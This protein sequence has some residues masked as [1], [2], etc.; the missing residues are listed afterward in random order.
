M[1]HRISQI[2]SLNNEKQ[3]IAVTTSNTKKS[4]TAEE[5]ALRMNIPIGIAKN[6]LKVTTQLGSRTTN[7]PSLT[8]KY[9]TNDRML[10]YARTSSDS[11]TD[12]FFVA[13]DAVS[14]R[15]FKACQVFAT[16]F[17]HIFAVPME[18]KSG[19]NIAHA[20]KKYFKICGV[21]NH[22]ICDQAK[23]QVRG[24][25]KILCHDAGCTIVELEKGAPAA[26]RAERAIKTLKD[27]S[28]KDMFDKGSPLVLWCYCVERRAKIINA[29]CR[30]NLLL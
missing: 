27:G 30:S 17:G 28:K 20:T 1:L 10:R 22:I 23:E 26:N 7:E 12:T 3:C 16:E 13:K 19:T 4:I 6:T 18:N 9:R 5:L 21:P 11:F 25:A 14:I 29:T 15:G 24:D 2:N 8:R